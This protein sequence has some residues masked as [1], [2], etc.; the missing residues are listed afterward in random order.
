MIRKL[1]ISLRRGVVTTPI[2][3]CLVAAATGLVAV[4]II[5]ATVVPWPGLR[6]TRSQL[7]LTTVG[8]TIEKLQALQD[9]AVQKVTVSDV[10]VYRN[11]WT[12]SWLVRGDGIISIPL[13]DSRIV[14][15]DEVRHT[16]RI[17][18][19]RPRVL[20]A[21]VDHEKTFYY[22]SKQGLWNR[23]NPWGESYPEVSQEAHR[24]MQRLIEHAVSAPEHFD[25]SQL[26]ATT[27]VRTLYSSLGWQVSVDWAAE[28]TSPLALPVPALETATPGPPPST[29]PKPKPPT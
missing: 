17:I 25:Q 20:T 29:Q 2:V 3:I 7:I 10:M 18:L 5:L 6:W 16:A 24:Q 28:P 9:L 23:V 26:N 1:L 27:I 14:D 12:A 13:K 4:A 11:G 19:P 15:V 22:D 8:P 21:R